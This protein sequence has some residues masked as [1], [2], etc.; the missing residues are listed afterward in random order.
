MPAEAAEVPGTG[1]PATHEGYIRQV[2]ATL[3]R[4]GIEVSELT[5][6]ADQTRSAS[7]KITEREPFG[8]MSRNAERITLRWQEREGWSYQVQ[9]PE[10]DYRRERIFFGFSAV[11]E[12]SQIA[13]WL[14]VSLAHPE[15]EP[16]H[17]G[18]P[19]ETPDLDV[20]LRAY[21]VTA[22]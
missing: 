10:D 14:T 8:E 22:L 12:P 11:P 9:Y 19:F 6:S 2:T 15:I 20:V 13:A 16:N 3:D 5:I 1:L 17:N 18:G 21:S 7:M 4:Q